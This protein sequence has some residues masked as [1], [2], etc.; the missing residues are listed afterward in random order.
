MKNFDGGKDFKFEC[1][2]LATLAAH[3][4][5]DIEVKI[6]DEIV[7]KINFETNADVIGI[8][9]LTYNAPRAYWIAD[10][11]RKRG[12]KV[13]LGGVHVSLCSEEAKAHAD[14]IIKGEAELII[15]EIIRDIKVNRLKP[16]YSST[17]IDLE[18]IKS[19]RYELLSKKYLPFRLIQTVRGCSNNCSFCSINDLYGK[20][21]RYRN[22]DIVV[23]DIYTAPYKFIFFTDNNFHQT[24][25]HSLTIM[26][27][28]T[29]ARK[30]WTGYASAIAGDDKEWLDM[31]QESG[32]KALFIGFESL[33]NKCL[34]E[35]DKKNNICKYREQIKN[36]KE[37]GIAV[38]GSFIFGFDNETKSCFETTLK[39]I[40][41][42]RIDM[43]ICSVLTPFPGTKLYDNL[44]KENRLND[45][46][47]WLNG[48]N[49]YDMVFSPKG[50]LGKEEIERKIELILKEF[51]KFR[52]FFDR[53]FNL[54]LVVSVIDLLAYIIAFFIQR[55]FNIIKRKSQLLVQ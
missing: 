54:P 4:P 3:I 45:P 26:S 25:N 52:H 49:W 5:D 21:I 13:L 41:E 22:I 14:A 2:T 47:W 20:R 38:V 19:P 31:A 51:Y 55:K 23:K 39:F 48:K 53:L 12:K 1:I 16:V 40:L 37:R 11:F 9:S 33:D 18:K 15:P 30:S 46:H 36:I 8:S 43:L 6:T 50:E 32:C 29:G 42:N 35:V 34:N 17:P 44:L 24:R 10:E 27:E 7:E 28:I